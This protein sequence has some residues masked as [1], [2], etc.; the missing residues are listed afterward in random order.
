[1]KRY[2]LYAIGLAIY[3]VA[4]A[5][6]AIYGYNYYQTMEHSFIKDAVFWYVE[7][8]LT[9]S[10]AGAAVCAIIFGWVFVRH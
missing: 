4:A 5:Y 7:G 9:L 8:T 10:A 6:G 3:A 1:M 2:I